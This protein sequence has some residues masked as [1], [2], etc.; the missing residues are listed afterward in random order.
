MVFITVIIPVKNGAATL[1]KC[2]K[3]IEEQTIAD[4]IDLIILD[5]ASTDNSVEIAE[6]FGAKVIPVQ[7]GEFNHGLTR[8]IG[9]DLA[10]GHLLFYT[11]QDAW[12]TAKDQLEKMAGHFC[13]K[14]LDAVAGIQAVPA[15]KDKNPARWFKRYS[16]PVTTYQY[17]NTDAFNRFSDKEKYNLVSHWD[18]VNAMYRKE[19]L[20]KVPFVH[21]GFAEDKLWAR[22]AISK[23][24][25]LA[26]DPSLVVYH[27]HHRN[28]IYSFRVQYVFNYSLYRHFKILPGVPPII[29]PVLTSWY[30]VWKNNRINA[31]EKFYW[32]LHNFSGV[33]GS[34]LSHLA[35]III[36][37]LG[38]KEAVGRS[39]EFFCNEIPQGKIK[40]S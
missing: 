33:L 6:R 16:E 28:F 18:N 24:M 14:Q 15:E 7:P 34:Y 12:L 30:L 10:H 25:K 22:D 19:S 40:D 26:F 29:K 13:D 9:V 32:T 17:Y 20:Q 5:T 31:S 37:K 21:T 8:N 36:E 2:L 23:E 3:S 39:L 11:V 4:C 35:F 1:Q 27:Y 38:G